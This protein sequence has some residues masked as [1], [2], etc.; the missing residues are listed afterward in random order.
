[1]SGFSKELCFT[2]LWI[3]II[4]HPLPPFVGYYESWVMEVHS[5]N[6]YKSHKETTHF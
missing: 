5:L 3:S 4:L 6:S 2:K 1:M